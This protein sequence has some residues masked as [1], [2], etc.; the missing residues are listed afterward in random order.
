MNSIVRELLERLAKE[1]RHVVADWRAMVV[2]QR[3]VREVPPEQRRWKKVPATPTEARHLLNSMA[4]AGDMR[5]L[6]DVLGV[7]EVIVPYADVGGV[8]ELE[9]LMETH[10]CVAASHHTAM[11][12]HGLTDDQ[13]KSIHAMVPT[14]MGDLGVPTG[15]TVQD[16]ESLPR[17]PA[18]FPAQILGRVVRWHRVQPKRFV[19]VREYF[20]E[21]WSVRVTT[22]ERTLIDGLLTPEHCGGIGAVLQGWARARDL[23]A[24]DDAV[25]IVE[26]L[27]IAVLRQRVGFIMESLGLAHDALESW[28]ARSVRG[29]SSRLCANAP[30]ASTFS[31]RW[32]LS[33]NA[34]LDA[35]QRDA[36]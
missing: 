19:G 21:G 29:G 17:A 35:L 14:S 18:R 1:R 11:G 27:D 12:F 32:S 10:P 28:R 2:L 23:F 24:V 13:P 36:A 4:S 16:W 22:P 33:L 3:A 26:A 31:E 15:T 30:Y 5:E 34:P 20:P 6:D 25:Q 8:G 9:V 7:Y